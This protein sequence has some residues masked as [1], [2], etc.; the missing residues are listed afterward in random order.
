MKCHWD[1]PVLQALQLQ[2]RNW[3]AD[4][5]R[6]ADFKV[7]RRFKPENFGQPTS[8]QLHHFSDASQGGYGTVSYLRMQNGEHI[9]VASV[10]GKARVAPLKQMTIPR[11]ELT[12]AVL[13]VRVDRMLQA[14]LQ[15]CL[16]KSVFWTVSTS[17]LKYIRDE[18]KRF[19][20]VVANRISAIREASD[21]SQWRYIPTAQNPADDASRG[22]RVEHLLTQNR[23]IEGPEFLGKAEEKWPI[24]SMLTLLMVI[25]R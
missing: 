7:S 21:I 22:L 24:M 11:M 10:L 15:L 8:V 18:D 13:A 5:K 20:T 2:W 6:V 17:V 25:Q 23:W 9:H 16:E 1:D 4:L 3:L 19:H 14:E 12:A